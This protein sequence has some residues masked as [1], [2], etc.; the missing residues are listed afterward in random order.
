MDEKYY[1]EIEKVIAFS[2]KISLNYDCLRAIAFELNLG[3]GFSEAANDLNILNVN[4]E[5]YNFTLHLENGEILHYY[6]FRTNLFDNDGTYTWA[7]MYN[8][9]GQ[10]VLDVRYD[11]CHNLRK[12]SRC[13]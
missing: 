2:Q 5:E 7:S 8:N 3:T 6:R 4:R 1:G 13:W 10:E 9:S 12:V 11:K